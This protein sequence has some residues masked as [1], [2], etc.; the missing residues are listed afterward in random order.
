MKDI[1]YP[2]ILLKGINTKIIPGI[3]NTNVKKTVSIT[4][5]SISLLSLKASEINRINENTNNEL[6]P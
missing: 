1:M 4:A 2:N 5:S 6:I 3:K